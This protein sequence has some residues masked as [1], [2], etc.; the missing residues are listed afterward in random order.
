MHLRTTELPVFD[1][2][3][4]VVGIEGIVQDITE[5]KQA[6]A[7]R[8]QAI[9]KLEKALSEIRTL[10]GILP[11]CSFCKKV[12]DD[13]GYW[14]QVDIYLLK[15]SEAGISHSVCPECMKRHYPEEYD[16]IRSRSNE[17]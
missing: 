5:L 16:A 6:E 14:E 3:G 17:D 2:H 9:I 15:H 11:L 12:R 8:E 7:K 10:R 13:Q 4:T 1:D